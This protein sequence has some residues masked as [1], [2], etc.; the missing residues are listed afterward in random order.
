M[1]E[2]LLQHG[3]RRSQRSKQHALLSCAKSAS[4]RGAAGAAG[5]GGARPGASLARLPGPP[6]GLGGGGGGA[7]PLLGAG[8]PPALLAAPASACSCAL[9]TAHSLRAAARWSF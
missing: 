4:M 9:G 8:F 6:A 5:P 7:P 2:G 1:H 3:V